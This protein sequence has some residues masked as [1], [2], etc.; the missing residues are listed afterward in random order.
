MGEGS[1]FLLSDNEAY[2]GWQA[3]LCISE[4]HP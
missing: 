2:A 4:A 1:A 3:F